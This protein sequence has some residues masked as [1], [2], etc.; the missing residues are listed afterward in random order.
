[1][2]GNYLIYHMKN[3]PH[4]N[5]EKYRITKG[6]M[7]SDKSYGNNG[8]FEIPGPQ[9]AVLW[10]IASN[11][12][13]WDHVS[14]HVEGRCPT[15]KELCFIKDLFWK[16][17]ETVIQYHPPKSEY[18]NNHPFVLHLWKPQGIDVPMPLLEFV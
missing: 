6:P 4:K 16:P 18:V 13:G 8:A 2:R 14:V 7:A 12:G 3:N 9:K 5:A 10:T 1:M 15:W 17:E 11:E